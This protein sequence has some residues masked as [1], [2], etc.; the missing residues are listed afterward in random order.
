MARSRPTLNA[1]NNASSN[2]RHPYC[3]KARPADQSQRALQPDACPQ[4]PPRNRRQQFPCV[5]MLRVG[6]DGIGVAV[7][8]GLALVHHQ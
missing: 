3:P 1:F 2:N 7:F 5:F 4:S 8:D 6:V